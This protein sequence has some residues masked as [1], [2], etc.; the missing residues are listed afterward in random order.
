MR[1][2]RPAFGTLS[3]RASPVSANWRTAL[4]LNDRITRM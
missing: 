3:L 4:L 1:R 2:T